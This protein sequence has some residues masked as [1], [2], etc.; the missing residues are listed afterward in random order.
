M[1]FFS[2][3]SLYG[4]LTLVELSTSSNRKEIQIFSFYMCRIILLHIAAVSDSKYT[5]EVLNS[6]VLNSSHSLDFFP[7]ISYV[8]VLHCVI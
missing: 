2:C 1:F 7:L 3:S 6:S 4:N 8:L 5:S